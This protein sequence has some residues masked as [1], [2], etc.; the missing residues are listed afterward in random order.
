M[1]FAGD[2]DLVDNTGGG[3]GAVCCPVALFCVGSFFIMFSLLC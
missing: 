1:T 3:T 2:L